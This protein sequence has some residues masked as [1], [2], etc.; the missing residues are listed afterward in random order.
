MSGEMQREVVHRATATGEA[1]NSIEDGVMESLCDGAIHRRGLLA[2]YLRF[3]G[4]IRST[5]SGGIW[6]IRCGPWGLR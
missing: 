5:A 3:T 6:S 2:D 4:H 1:D